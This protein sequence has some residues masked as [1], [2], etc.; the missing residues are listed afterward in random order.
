M[1]SHLPWRNSERPFEPVQ[2]ILLM[3][4]GDCPC[5]A[6]LDQWRAYAG[7]LIALRNIARRFGK[8]V[9]EYHLDDFR[10]PFSLEPTVC[11]EALISSFTWFTT[12]LS[13]LLLQF[14]GQGT[15]LWYPKDERQREFMYMDK[16][17]TLDVYRFE[18]RP[19]WYVFLMKG[20]EVGVAYSLQHAFDSLVACHALHRKGCLWMSNELSMHQLYPK[21]RYPGEPNDDWYI[22][23][24]EHLHTRR[25]SP[26][27]ALRPMPIPEIYGC[28]E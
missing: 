16:A 10:T 26:S 28:T 12:S 21:K 17:L 19:H 4:A 1:T 7:K 25:S 14:A 13:K 5:C 11:A 24:S 15:Q 22:L 18:I 6:I 3:S 8:P 20:K 27:W 9:Y 23:M 2:P